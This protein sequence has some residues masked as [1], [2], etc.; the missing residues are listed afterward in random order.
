MWESFAYQANLIPTTFFQ[1]L[2]LT[3]ILG[4]LNFGFLTLSDIYW[5]HMGPYWTHMGPYG[6]HMG[7]IWDP[8]KPW[9]WCPLPLPG[10]PIFRNLTFSKALNVVSTAPAGGTHFQK[11]DFFQNG[12]P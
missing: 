9:M 7:P 11:S 2:F 8:K 12:N 6:T 1:A 10:E 3:M 5:G 4:C